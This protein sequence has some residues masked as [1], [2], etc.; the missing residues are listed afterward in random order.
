[1]ASQS[2]TRLTLVDE[3]QR[4]P[5]TGDESLTEEAINGW[6]PGQRRCRAR[7]RHNW[8]PHTVWEHGSYYDVVERCP[9]CK[10]RRHADF[11]KRGRQLTKWKPDY[12]KDYLLPKG[13]APMNEDFR[14]D[15]V[16]QD[17]LSRK[18]VEV[19][20]DEDND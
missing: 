10:N 6:S 17:I 13:A 18:I 16:L 14:D 4:P 3:S 9:H 20:D 15:L 7:K 8:G 11:S 5:R 1:M 12:R 2:A 19:T